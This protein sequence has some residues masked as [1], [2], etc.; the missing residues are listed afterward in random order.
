MIDGENIQVRRLI[1]DG[2]KFID[3]LIFKF[4]NSYYCDGQVWRITTLYNFKDGKLHCETGPAIK[5]G[6]I[7]LYYLDGK[8]Y[9]FN[10]F[11]AKQANT[12]HAAKIMSEVLGGR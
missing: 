11:W 3:D 5:D 9:T 8:H 7:Q 10:E 12:E 4:Y 6:D 1:F 2:A